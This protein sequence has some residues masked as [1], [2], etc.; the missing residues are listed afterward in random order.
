M[1][2][3]REPPAFV[4]G[5]CGLTRQNWS[6]QVQFTA[7]D[8]GGHEQVRDLWEEYYAG[9]DAIV[10]MVDSADK[11]RLPEAKR[12]LGD[13]L[14]HEA[15]DGELAFRSPM[16]DITAGADQA[17]LCAGVPLL[18]LGNK[19]DLE[20]SMGK[21]ELV[22]SLGCDLDDGERPVELYLSSLIA[23]TGY[24]QGFQWLSNHL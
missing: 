9:A 14:K 5:L 21:A 20:G 4:E 18:I 11:S 19:S 24:T 13:L 22:K 1:L 16:H 17:V 2:P 7:W 8:L 10:F 15:V 12:E 23:G 3:T 6:T